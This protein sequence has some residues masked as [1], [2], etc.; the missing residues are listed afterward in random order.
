MKIQPGHGEVRPPRAAAAGDAM[1]KA[2][3]NIFLKRGGAFEYIKAG[4]RFRRRGAG[5]LVET[6]RVLAICSDG[7][8]IPHVRYQVRIER[9]QLRPV[10]DGPRILNLR[11]FIERYRERAGA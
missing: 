9:P 2:Y 7:A 10:E 5:H 4:Q 6:A 8:G 11:S 3:S 1:G